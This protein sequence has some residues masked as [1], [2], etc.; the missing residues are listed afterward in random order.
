MARVDQQPLFV[1]IEPGQVVG[2]LAPRPRRQLKHRRRTHVHVV[3]AAAAEDQLQV[4]QRK[5]KVAEQEVLGEPHCLPAG[6]F[7]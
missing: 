4:L 3:A 6:D 2:Q 7:H 1:G 5:A